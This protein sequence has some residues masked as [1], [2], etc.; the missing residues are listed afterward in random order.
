[1]IVNIARVKILAAHGDTGS[2]A[3]YLRGSLMSARPR[4]AFALFSLFSLFFGGVSA[5]VP[6]ACVPATPPTGPVAPPPT[7]AGPASSPISETAAPAG[8]SAPDVSAPALT[9]APAVS[10][11]APATDP[12]SPFDRDE[13]GVR[14]LVL[15]RLAV[16]K[17]VRAKRVWAPVAAYTETSGK[18]SFRQVSWRV[19][20]V[21]EAD[22]KR[23]VYEEAGQ[24]YAVPASVVV[25]TPLRP[26]P[27]VGAAVHFMVGERHVK[28]R[29][30]GFRGAGAARE[31]LCEAFPLEN[32]PGE[33]SVPAGEVWL[34][35][36]GVAPGADGWTR[37]PE[38]DDGPDDADVIA[39]QA[40]HAWVLRT[41]LTGADV[42]ASRA[43]GRVP[44][45]SVIIVPI[46]DGPKHPRGDGQDF[47][48]PKRRALG[49]PEP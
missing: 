4:R 9:A 34:I 2:P 45:V 43:W 26:T 15:P 3:W 6:F 31:A 14:T 35:A 24:R 30:R 36:G 12:P 33:H 41:N 5:L 20:D 47:V 25:P 46:P 16:A 17:I 23:V 28:G 37:E 18:L 42:Q 11:A 40:G 38:K 8:E 49:L 27:P 44:I 22:G 10:A 19:V 48:D 29:L 21:I 13:D 32:L 1:M 7:A 39:V